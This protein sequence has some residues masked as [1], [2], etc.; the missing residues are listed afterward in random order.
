MLRC[1]CFGMIL[2]VCYY[3]T[4]YVKCIFEVI[5]DVQCVRFWTCAGTHVYNMYRLLS[6]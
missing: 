1:I 3:I 5:I 6:S 2:A 4:Y